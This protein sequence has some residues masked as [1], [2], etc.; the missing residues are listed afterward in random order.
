MSNELL[1]LIDKSVE[2]EYNMEFLYHDFAVK[3]KEHENFWYFLAKEESEHGSLIADFKPLVEM[4]QYS[5][6][7][8]FVDLKE[9]D[10]MN[11]LIV[12]LR[13]QYATENYNIADTLNLSLI[14]ESS[15]AEQHY[16]YVV[17]NSSDDKVINAFKFLAKADDS[18]KVRIKNY[19]NI[20][21]I[22]ENKEKYQVI[23][24]Y[25]YDSVK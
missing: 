18:H 25:L 16:W 4:N 23:I 11:Q 6:E 24:D 14:L 9:L 10:Y 21:D 7:L 13:K 12:E 8:A 22:K 17:E 2:L 3:Q 15:A 5:I 1:K 19:M 20:L